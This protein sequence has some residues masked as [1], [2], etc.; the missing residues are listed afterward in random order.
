[1]KPLALVVS[2]GCGE[3]GRV[4]P[5]AS[6]S[7][8]VCGRTYD[9]AD[10]PGDEYAAVASE[11]NRTKLR[12]LI[13]FAVIAAVFVPLGF[14]LGAELWITGAVVLAV[15]YFA[16][17]PKLKRDVRRIVRDLPLWEIREHEEGT[18]GS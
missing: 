8:P 16:Y 4:E 7:C 9:T 3:R 18:P 15:F 10:I 12:A 1:V 17:G 11:V 14:L 6:W 13:G 5:G 2:C